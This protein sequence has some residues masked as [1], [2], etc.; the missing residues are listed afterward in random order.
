MSI[1]ISTDSTPASPTLGDTAHAG[2]RARFARL[3]LPQIVLL[4]LGALGC[5]EPVVEAAPTTLNGADTGASEADAVAGNDGEQSDSGTTDTGSTG[6]EWYEG[7][8]STIKF[9]GQGQIEVMADKTP[10]DMRAVKLIMFETLEPEKDKVYVWWM[11]SPSGVVANY[12]TLPREDVPYVPAFSVLV[13]DP[14][15]GTKP[16][17]ANFNGAFVTYETAVGADDLAKPTGPLV[18]KGEIPLNAWLHVQHVLTRKDGGGNEPG[19][20]QMADAI[21]GEVKKQYDM[22][23]A[24]FKKGNMKEATGHAE[25]IHNLLVGDKSVKDLN[26]D[27]A[28]AKDLTKYTMGLAAGDTPLN[29]ALKHAKFAKDAGATSTP[30][31][32][33]GVVFL[34]T[35][36]KGFNDNMLTALQSLEAFASG[37]DKTMVTIDGD[38]SKLLK[39]HANAVKGAQKLGQINLDL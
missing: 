17:I 32:D 31:L 12:G 7:P 39:F 21:M 3:A 20:I 4:S 5:G 29:Q 19:Y 36:V 16:H 8:T 6:S 11:R 28:I 13:A 22:T 27:S 37:E 38:V 26:K 18:W 24:A 35:A 1:M 25:N 30:G 33:A 14:G 23:K 9:T 34:E 2:F 15:D 10:A